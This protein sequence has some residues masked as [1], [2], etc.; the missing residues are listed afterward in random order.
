MIEHL[1]A[2]A[3]EAKLDPFIAPGELADFVYTE[4][5]VEFGVHLGFE[6]LKDLCAE[7]GAKLSLLALC[8]ASSETPINR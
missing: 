2:R 3:F 1:V 6:Q 5:H 8:D 7:V 4:A